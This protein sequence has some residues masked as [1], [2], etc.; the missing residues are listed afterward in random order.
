MSA[1]RPGLPMVRTF[2]EQSTERKGAKTAAFTTAR[3]RAHCARL[4]LRADPANKRQ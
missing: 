3:W 1:P 4:S 2:A